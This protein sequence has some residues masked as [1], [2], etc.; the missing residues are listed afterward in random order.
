LQDGES[1]REK[2]TEVGSML[3]TETV[4]VGTST[5]SYEEEDLESKHAQHK[6][7]DQVLTSAF[8]EG[9]LGKQTLLHPR[10]MLKNIHNPNMCLWVIL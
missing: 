5:C 9:A 4:E 2:V 10:G 1:V 6:F 7:Q 3:S 8:S